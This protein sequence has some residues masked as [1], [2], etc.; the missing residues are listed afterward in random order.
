ML[1]GESEHKEAKEWYGMTNKNG[2]KKQIALKQQRASVLRGI[3]QADVEV[4]KAR[5]EA[6]AGT[7]AE[8][9]REARSR[10]R[11]RQATYFGCEEDKLRDKLDPVEFKEHHQMSN[12]QRA[13][14]DVRNIPWKNPDDPV[15]QVSRR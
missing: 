3:K 14:E 1:Q 6:K 11:P 8:G 12:S 4:T 2:H 7:S 10:G 5:E 9:A 15:L 13:W